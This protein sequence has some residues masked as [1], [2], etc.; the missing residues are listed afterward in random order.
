[1]DTDKAI[2]FVA[3]YGDW[4]SIKKLKIEPATEP[5]TIMEF[6]ASLGT[7]IDSKVEANLRKTVELAKLDSV[8]AEIP[9]G[10]SEKE[11]A[12]ALRGI[13]SR[14]VSGVIN[15]ITVLE[16]FQKNEQKEL[17]QFCKVYAMRK[18][19]NECGLGIDY[20]G[21]DIPGMKRMKKVKG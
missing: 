8:L 13:N 21:I 3:N 6:L 1:M 14:A 12:E 4:V 19:L 15:E 20:S 9:A 17:G 10:K 18:K 7:G 11:I 5:R 2:Q 16:K